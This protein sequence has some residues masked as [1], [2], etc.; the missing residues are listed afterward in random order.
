MPKAVPVLLLALAACS[1]LPE[2]RVAPTADFDLDGSGR[3]GAWSAVPWTPLAPR[4]PAGAVYET[5]VKALYSTSGL[6]FLFD[7]TDRTLT[8][9]PQEDQGMLWLEDVFEVF[10]WPEESVPVYFEYEVSPYG[11]ELAIVVPNVG[12]R[13]HGWL[14][15]MY[16]GARKARKAAQVRGGPLRKGAAIEGWSAEVFLPYELLKPLPA[17]PPGPGTR[18]RGNFYRMDYDFPERVQWAWAPVEGNFHDYRRFG[19]LRFE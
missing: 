17:A 10:V 12:G 18:W 14:P 2:L 8:A 4:Q 11:K 15:W 1:S 13:F 3:A 7:G 16:G 5:R 19:V 6:Y 9:S